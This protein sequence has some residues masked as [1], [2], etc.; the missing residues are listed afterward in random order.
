MQAIG[1]WSNGTKQF[2][3]LRNLEFD[4]QSCESSK[5]TA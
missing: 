1:N 2:D 5:G 4:V 3:F